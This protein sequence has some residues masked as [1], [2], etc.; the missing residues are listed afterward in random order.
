MSMGRSPRGFTPAD[1]IEENFVVHPFRP[2]IATNYEVGLKSLLEHRVQLDAA[3]FYTTYADRLYLF[4]QL[5][6]TAITDLTTNI[7]P[8]TN[9]GAEFRRL[10]A[11]LP[12]R[13]QGERRSGCAAGDVGQD[14][15]FRQSRQW[16]RRAANTQSLNV[17]FA[18]AYTANTTLDWKHNFAGYVVGARADGVVH[19]AVLLGSPE[20]GLSAGIPSVEYVRVA[21]ARDMES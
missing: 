15:G 11:P 17:P 3:I 7:G 1:E 10:A 13:I 14:H 21:R 8:S 16:N 4:Q 2:E 6:G 12:R 9:Y 19:R 5:A 18:P 20:L